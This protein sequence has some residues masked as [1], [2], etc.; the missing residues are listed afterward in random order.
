M[1]NSHISVFSKRLGT[2]YPPRAFPEMSRKAYVATRN[3]ANPPARGH[4]REFVPEFPIGRALH[5]E[6]KTINL[7]TMTRLRFMDWQEKTTRVWTG[8]FVSVHFQGPTADH[9]T[10]QGHFNRMGPLRRTD[11]RLINGL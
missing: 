10:R 1:V 6:H 8:V 7:R 4:I 3:L 9:C 11:R 5:G 2:I